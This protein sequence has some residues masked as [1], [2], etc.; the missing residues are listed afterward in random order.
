MKLDNILKA[1]GFTDKQA[2]VYVACLEL[3]SAS[4]QKISQKAELPRSTCYE[5]LDF[6]LKESVVSTFFKKKTRYFSADDPEKLLRI[7][8]EKTLLL[9]NGIMALRALYQKAP[10]KNP[11]IRFYEG[12]RGITMVLQEILEES[13]KLCAIAS[14]EDLFNSLEKEFPRFVRE[15]VKKKIPVQVILRASPKAEERKRLGPSELRDVRI[16]P[17]YFEFQGMMYLWKNKIAMIS[18]EAD[19]S[20]V[21]VENE[22]LVKI[23]RAMF[24][25]MWEKLGH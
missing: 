13:Q 12:R 10:T 14:A 5:I 11:T 4:V 22:A 15:R 20:A 7:S 21:I 17:E 1:Y 3:G 16:I 24:E 2:R 19:L 6:L 23:Q 8:R 9:E 18:F 25:F